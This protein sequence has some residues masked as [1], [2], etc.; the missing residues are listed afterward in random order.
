M[1]QL[2]AASDQQRPVQ[3]CSRHARAC[4]P[5]HGIHARTVWGPQSGTLNCGVVWARSA[6]VS[7][8][9]I[10]AAFTRY[11]TVQTYKTRCG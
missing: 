8:V 10:I 11:S 4:R 9:K 7:E 3:A 1:L 6:M 5:K 2:G